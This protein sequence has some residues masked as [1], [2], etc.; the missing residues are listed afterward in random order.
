MDL[1]IVIDWK[2]TSHCRWIS[3]ECTVP[4]NSLSCAFFNLLLYDIR[5]KENIQIKVPYIASWD[6][7]E[8]A[9]EIANSSVHVILNPVWQMCKDISHVLFS[10]A[11]F[12]FSCAEHFST[13]C[14]YI[15]LYKS[16]ENFPQ[17]L[18]VRT[19]SAACMR[20]EAVSGF[21]HRGIS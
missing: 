15:I 17:N 9:S 14:T 6:A 4:N 7:R 2:H 1:I 16:L 3:L 19:L 5:N 10:Q 8:A 12:F 18:Y 20:N 21:R 11:F 13:R